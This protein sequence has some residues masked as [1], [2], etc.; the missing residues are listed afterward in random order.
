VARR[1]EALS[2]ERGGRGFNLILKLCKRFTKTKK[3][4]SK[5]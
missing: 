1:V 5:I 3:D 4:V 2:V